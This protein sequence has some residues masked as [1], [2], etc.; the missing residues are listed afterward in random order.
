MPEISIMRSPS[1]SE[2]EEQNRG[3]DLGGSGFR[4][5]EL[6]IAEE[7][8]LRKTPSDT[9]V[10]ELDPT[11]GE[12]PRNQRDTSLPQPTG[13][14]IVIEHLVEPIYPQ[15]AIDAGIEGVAVFGIQVDEEGSVRRAWLIE[16]DVTGEC[17][18]EAQRAVLQWRFAPYRVDGRPAPFLKYYRFRFKLTDALRDGREARALMETGAS[19]G[20]P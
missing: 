18:I 17:N 4:V 9:E 16:S 1:Y 12:D 10:E 11:L 20:S 6:R 5:V 8:A 7:E 15:S 19:A 2:S 3:D 13:Q 14:E